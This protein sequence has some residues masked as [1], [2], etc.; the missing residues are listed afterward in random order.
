MSLTS[1]QTKVLAAIQ[2]GNSSTEQIATAS[3]VAKSSLTGILNGLISKGLVT[4]NED[5]SFTVTTAK[6]GKPEVKEDTSGTVNNSDIEPD[7]N[8]GL[9]TG[10]N[11]TSVL[12]PYLKSEAVGEE[13][14]YALRSWEKN[15]NDNIRVIV[16]GDKE[17]WFSPNIIHIP[18]EPH[19]IKED[20]ACPS[21]SMVR[22]P[23]ADVT[24][25][26]FAAIASGEISGDFILSNDDIFLV[27][28]TY[29]EDVKTLKAFGTLFKQQRDNEPLRLY[30]RNANRTSD[31]LADQGLP[32]HRYG[33]H[34][35]MFLNAEKLIEVIE[36]HKSLENGHLI[37]SL[38]FNVLFPNARP[39]Q[40]D[41]SINDPILASVYRPDVSIEILDKIF[42][43]RKF[44]NCDSKGWPAVQPFLKS[45]FPDPSKYEL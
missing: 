45:L 7:L 29:L 34:T 43:T 32:D 35:P 10:N 14:K 39:I 19:L 3:G 25:K 41:G 11:A 24:H 36:K 9:V 38:Y 40:I 37:T 4:K 31:L 5:K 26:I 28:S 18:I 1:N 12:I 20:C 2:D 16:V 42:K 30:Q 8:P 13:L 44:I 15:Y 22:N 23:Q 6:E 27:G 33:T 17:D 21:P